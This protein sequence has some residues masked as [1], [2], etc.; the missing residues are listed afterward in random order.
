MLEYSDSLKAQTGIPE[1]GIPLLFEVKI[2]P[3]MGVTLL[4]E[5]KIDPGNRYHVIIRGVN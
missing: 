4:F 2:D 5:V 3:G 1:M